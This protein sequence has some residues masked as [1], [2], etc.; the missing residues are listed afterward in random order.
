MLAEKHQKLHQAFL[1][2][3]EP[4]KEDDP[5]AGEFEALKKKGWVGLLRGKSRSALTRVTKK[6]AG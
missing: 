5:H 1:P 4:T 6:K 3:M 2:G